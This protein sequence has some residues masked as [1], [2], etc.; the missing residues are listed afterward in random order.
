GVMICFCG[1]SE[2]LRINAV[3]AGDNIK[4]VP[5]QLGVNLGAASNEVKL[6]N[7]TGIEP[8][9]G[10]FDVPTSNVIVLK[11]ALLNNGFTCS[12]RGMGCIDK[13]AA[14]AGDPVR[15]SHHHMGLLAGY[16]GIAFKLTDL[17]AG[18]FIENNLR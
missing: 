4:I 14:I 15:V 11:L 2:G 16:L 9:A 1:G 18:H 5:V 13:T 6:A 7:I 17:P 3:T 10:N 12:Q 8:R